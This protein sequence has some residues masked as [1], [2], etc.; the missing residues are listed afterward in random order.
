MELIFQRIEKKYRMNQQQYET[1]K[2]CSKSYMEIDQYGLHTICNL[3][4]DTEDDRLVRTS[5]DKP[6][7]KE[8]LRL[9]S[10]GIPGKQDTV[11]LELKKKWEG[12]V[13]KRR[14]PMTLEEAD[15]YLEYGELPCHDQ[16]MM[17]EIDYFIKFYEPV[18]KVYL[19][20]DREAFFGKEDGVLRLTIDRRIRTRTQDLQLDLGD[21]GETLMEEGEYLME[22]KVP[23][24]YPV[25]LAHLLADL[26]IYPTSFSKYGQYYVNS[27]SRQAV[28]M[29]Y[30]GKEEERIQENEHRGEHGRESLC[31][32]VF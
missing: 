27:F 16:Q 3:Y 32:P 6:P 1:F 25:W 8:K 31:L 21:Y 15:A 2:E 26:E 17:R 5:I 20:Y 12:I 30:E 18:P 10:Y 11:F 9:R 7:Y 23:S 28:S 29:G 24:A 4:F 14:V 22:I 13:Y 19:A